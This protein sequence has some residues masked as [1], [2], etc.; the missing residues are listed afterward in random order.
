MSARR[1]ARYRMRRCCCVARFTPELISDPTE[2]PHQAFK[3]AT[4]GIG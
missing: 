2:A 4:S 3:I 1:A